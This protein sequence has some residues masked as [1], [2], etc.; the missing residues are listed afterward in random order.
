MSKQCTVA[1][2]CYAAKALPVKYQVRPTVYKVVNSLE[3]FFM[4]AE[5]TLSW[6]RAVWP[7]SAQL[8]WPLYI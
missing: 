2:N 3:K 6:N 8:L 7:T 4:V 1:L 5:K